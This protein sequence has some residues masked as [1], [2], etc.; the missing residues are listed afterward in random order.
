MKAGMNIHSLAGRSPEGISI[1]LIVK[2]YSSPSFSAW[3]PKRTAPTW[4]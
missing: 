1:A 3:L 2:P 4:T